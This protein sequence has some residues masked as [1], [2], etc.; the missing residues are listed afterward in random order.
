VHL[1]GWYKIASLF[2]QL[3][4]FDPQ[5]PDRLISGDAVTKYTRNA[6]PNLHHHLGGVVLQAMYEHMNPS[7]FLS[8]LYQGKSPTEESVRAWQRIFINKL[9]D[10][11]SHILIDSPIPRIPDTLLPRVLVTHSL[12]I[13]HSGTMEYEMERIIKK[14]NGDQP[15]QHIGRKI[16]EGTADFYKLK[17]K[18][19][20]T[21]SRFKAFLEYN[22][23]VKHLAAK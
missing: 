20:P 22:R 9:Y 4:A 16:L 13:P 2:E 19:A 10:S 21:H 18:E 15:L 23:V 3:V 1:A 8:T 14:N 17:L 5:R 6:T 12:I 7:D 11:L